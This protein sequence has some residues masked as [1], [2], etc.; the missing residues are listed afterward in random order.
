MRASLSGDRLPTTRLHRA[1]SERYSLRS[2]RGRSAT[3]SCHHPEVGEHPLRLGLLAPRQ[4]LLAAEPSEGGALCVD[5][6]AEPIAVGDLLVVKEFDQPVFPAFT[7][8]G[9]IDQSAVRDPHLVINAENYHAL[10]TLAFTHA[11]KADC[12]YID[13]PY[14]TG[15]RDWKYNNDY[16][17]TNDRFRHS[18]WL[19]FMEKRLSLA[20]SLLKRDGVLIVTIDE[21]EFAHLGVLVEQLFPEYLRYIVT[22]VINSKGT[23]K[24]T[25]V[26]SENTPSF[27]S[28]TPVRMS[29]LSCRLPKSSRAFVAALPGLDGQDV[30]LDPALERF[31]AELRRLEL[32]DAAGHRA[33]RQA[34]ARA[35]SRSP[36]QA[37]AEAATVTQ[38]ALTEKAPPRGRL[39][40]RPRARPRG[41]PT[42]TAQ[43]ELVSPSLSSRSRL[44][45]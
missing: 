19:S 43:P 4:L 29:S 35:A 12:I 1:S 24:P 25:L 17:D 5:L 41:R 28:P 20:K 45:S 33:H 32:K 30:R 44:A 14:N 10:Q 13:P 15:A 3:V 39:H 8:L 11:G 31:Q 21:H 40:E 36:D 2:I 27:L 22:I 6:G 16:V 9:R 23:A 38:Q 7:S 37:A 18:K 26:G 42:A 34:T